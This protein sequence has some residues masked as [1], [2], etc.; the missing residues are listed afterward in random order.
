MFSKI[1]S[2]SSRYRAM[3]R[4]LGR[5]ACALILCLMTGRIW[6]QSNT[7]HASSDLTALPPARDEEL[8]TGRTLLKAGKLQEAEAALRS[9]VSTI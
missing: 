7:P 3:A 9:Y 8:E 6:A 2:K 1:D 5:I 4:S